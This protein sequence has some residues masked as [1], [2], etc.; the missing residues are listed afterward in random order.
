MRIGAL[1]L[2][3]T[4]MTCGIVFAD[5]PPI[6]SD[7][8][9][10]KNGK[11]RLELSGFAALRS[12]RRSRTGDF[13]FVGS[14]E[15]EIPLRKR[16]SIG[17]KAYPLYFYDQDDSGEDAVLG[18]G[19]GPEFRVYAKNAQRKG[20]FFEIGSALLATTG[21]FDGNSG[22]LNFLNEAG[23]GYK[24]KRDWH[25]TAKFSHISNAGFASHNSGVNSA[26]IAVGYTFG[27]GRSR[28][29]ET[30]LIAHAGRVRYHGRPV[31]TLNTKVRNGQRR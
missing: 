1:I 9:G 2:I 11:W 19:I 16:L 10:W 31:Q 27:C 29:V 4:L 7:E 13:G 20:I 23:V 17:I 21:R 28:N 15:Y 26:G 6:D 30:A 3:G 24:F 8:T 25:I 5:V 12:G 14:A 18:V 22:A